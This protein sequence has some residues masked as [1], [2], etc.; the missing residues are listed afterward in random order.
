MVVIK[1]WTNTLRFSVW[2]SND[3]YLGLSIYR[4]GIFRVFFSTYFSITQHPTGRA[5]VVVVVSNQMP[6][7]E[8]DED[9]GRVGLDSVYS[10]I[11][12]GRSNNPIH[13]VS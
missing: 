13:Q 8:K 2:L 9:A 7:P 11:G 12:P 3:T 10:R 5:L 1:I 6:P 4:N